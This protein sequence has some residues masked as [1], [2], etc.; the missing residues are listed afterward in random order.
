MASVWMDKKP[1]NMLSTLAQA[2]VTRTAQRKQKD[3]S[4]ISVQCTDAVVLYKYMAGVDKGD[5]MRQYY[6]V[7]TKCTKYYK[8]MFWFLFDVTVT[9]AYTEG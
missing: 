6:R 5:Q 2:D 9:N 1:V 8:Y 3:G 7:R 4:R